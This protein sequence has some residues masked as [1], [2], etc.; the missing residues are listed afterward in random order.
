MDDRKIQRLLRIVNENPLDRRLFLLRRWNAL[1]GL[2]PKPIDA[3]ILFI[4]MSASVWSKNDDPMFWQENV[5]TIHSRSSR[6]IRACDGKVSKFIGD[7]VMAVFTG[8]RNEEN[9]IW[10]AAA[11]LETFGLLRDYFEP[12][13]DSTLW[14]FPVTVGVA[15]GPVYFLYRGDPFGFA[16]D[17]AARLQGAATPGAGLVFASTLARAG[18]VVK[19]S[20][21]ARFIGESH[22]ISVKSF[23]AV[24]VS[25]L[26]RPTEQVK[27]NDQAD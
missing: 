27:R 3:S 13:M 8:E 17:L 14:R 1:P 18:E 22:E 15:S 23:G 9:A 16:V 21:L 25:A 5:Y 6:I 20:P 24:A 10:C 11:L 2:E 7:S 26:S 19:R 12:D 4:D